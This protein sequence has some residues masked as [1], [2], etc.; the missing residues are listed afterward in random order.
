MA[1]QT[2][3]GREIVGG[4][5]EGSVLYADTGLS[6]WGGCDPQTGVIDWEHPQRF[7]LGAGES[8]S[9]AGDAAVRI[10]EWCAPVKLSFAVTGGAQLAAVGTGDP[11][12]MTG[13]AGPIR[14]TYRGRAMAIVRPLLGTAENATLSVSADGL[15]SASL[16][17]PIA[18]VRM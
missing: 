12:D 14:R 9:R 15:P 2:L 8:L 6:F 16:E 13:F 17:L 18:P 10:P 7:A 3:V 11:T 1:Q 5:A 4:A